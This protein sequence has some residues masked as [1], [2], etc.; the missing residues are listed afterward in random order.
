MSFNMADPLIGKNKLLRQAMSLAYDEATFI[1]LFYNGRAIPAQGPIPPGLAGYDPT[2]KTH[3]AIQRRKG[4]GAFSKSRIS[5]GKGLPPLEFATT[6]DSVGRQQS[7]YLTKIM[8]A[9]G[10]AIKVNTYSWP[11][12]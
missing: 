11:Q 7:E 8:A 5:G 1:D 2:L 9:V 4:Q 10:I 12:F 3:T 6:A